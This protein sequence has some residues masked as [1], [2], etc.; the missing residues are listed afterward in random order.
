VVRAGGLDVA[1]L[2]DCFRAAALHRALMERKQS[3]GFNAKTL[4]VVEDATPL[5]KRVPGG[6]G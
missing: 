6:P 5:M 2:H 1:G 4:N 3:P